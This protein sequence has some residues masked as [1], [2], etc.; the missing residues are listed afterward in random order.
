M[1]Y[2]SEYRPDPNFTKRLKQ[3]DPRLGCR[4][5]H[6]LRKFAITFDRVVGPPA[7]VLIVRSEGGDF[8]QPD[9]RE[10][11]VLCEGDLHKTDIKTRLDKADNYMR[12]Y[13]RDQQKEVESRIDLA[14]KDDK[15]QLKNAYRKSFN[16][17][18]KQSEFRRIQPKPKGKVF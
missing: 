9:K 6:D 12:E 18:S 5:R 8:R 10:L 14:T 1:I 11:D 15:I 2:S 13:R 4:F 3:L 16:L 17:G 7:E